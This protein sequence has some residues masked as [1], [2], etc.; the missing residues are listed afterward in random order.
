MFRSFR[1]SVITKINEMKKSQT[2][3]TLFYNSFVI[4]KNVTISKT[5]YKFTFIKACFPLSEIVVEIIQSKIIR[6]YNF[7]SL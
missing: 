5:Q 6:H 1:F 4:R 2:N 3:I 7:N